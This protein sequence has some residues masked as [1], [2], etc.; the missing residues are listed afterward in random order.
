[1]RITD[2]RYLRDLRRLNLALRLIKHEARTGTIREC[3]GLG[4]DRIR[5]LYH[6]YLRP[7]GV[8]T[9]RHRGRAPHAPLRVVA[10][11]RGGADAAVFAAFSGQCGVVDL[12]P[13]CKGRYQLLSLPLGEAICEA[14]DLYRELVPEG[15]LTFEQAFCLVKALWTRDEIGPARCKKCGALIVVDLLSLHVPLCAACAAPVADSACSSPVS[16]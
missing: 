15:Q 7:A 9:A 10:S 8:C 13:G 5:R 14:F 1:M 3:T 4:D 11:P 6:Q 2:E 12:A 16:S